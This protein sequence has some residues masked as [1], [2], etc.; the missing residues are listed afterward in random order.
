[1]DEKSKNVPP[2]EYI[3]LESLIERRLYK[4]FVMNGYS[5]RPQVKCGPYRI[6]LVISRIA[7]ECDRKQHHSLL[8]AQK[9][10]DRKKDAYLRKQGYKV[11]RTSG[12]SIANRLPQVLKRVKTRLN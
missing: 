1:M 5:V 6:D 7:I 9:A 3:K 4:A 8:L 10:N 12:S 2:T 11:M